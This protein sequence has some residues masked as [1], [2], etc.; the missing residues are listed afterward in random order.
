VAEKSSVKTREVTR[1]KILDLIRENSTIT[2]KQMADEIGITRKEGR[3]VNPR[4]LT[5]KHENSPNRTE[6][7]SNVDC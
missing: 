5:D 3:R 6:F 1:E 4:I 7:Q 2:M